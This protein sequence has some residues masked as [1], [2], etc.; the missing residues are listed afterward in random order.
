MKLVRFHFVNAKIIINDEKRKSKY[1][2]KKYSVKLYHIIIRGETPK[3]VLL[4]S[5]KRVQ[6][7]EYYRIN[8]AEV[9]FIVAYTAYYR[10]NAYRV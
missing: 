4:L 6:S 9:T 8:G 1:F 3:R 5:I 10:Y 7:C 2:L